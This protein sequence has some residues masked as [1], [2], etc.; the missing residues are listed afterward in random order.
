M[1]RTPPTPSIR[2]GLPV[3][4]AP[5][6]VHECFVPEYGLAAHRR[7]RVA[8]NSPG[9]AAGTSCGARCTSAAGGAAKHPIEDV[10]PKV[11]HAH[12][13]SHT[14]GRGASRASGVRFG[15]PRSRVWGP[16]KAHRVFPTTRRYCGS[17]LP[18]SPRRRAREGAPR[19]SRAPWPG[20]GHGARSR[21]PCSEGEGENPAGGRVEVTGREVTLKRVSGYLSARLRSLCALALL[22]F[23]CF[24]HPATAILVVCLITAPFWP[25]IAVGMFSF[26]LQRLP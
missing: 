10:T 14:A 6:S 4:P 12:R 21:R 15:R 17:A 13:P 3:A 8:T 1:L 19:R 22:A 18:S 11:A 2:P 20:S 24:G 5:A 26:D 25:V 23:L 7:S 9:P 16:G